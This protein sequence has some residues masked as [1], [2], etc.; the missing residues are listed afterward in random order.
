MSADQPERRCQNQG[1]P[2]QIERGRRLDALY[3]S[4]ECR[5]D[6]RRKERFVRLK[7]TE[8]HA[9]SFQHLQDQL[10]YAPTEAVRYA[11]LGD[12]DAAGQRPRY[13]PLGRRSKHFDNKLYNI[14]SYS[15]RPFEPPRVPRPGV[16]GVLLFDALGRE[17]KRPKALYMGV[18]IL[19]GFARM[20][21]PG[22][23]K[24]HVPPAMERPDWNPKDGK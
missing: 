12:E 2:N 23:T 15:L 14:G 3:C 18:R 5:R 22:Q 1:C 6:A 8:P 4:P 13:P 9:A 11:L 21:L 16:Y 7:A 19:V 20:K 10:A 17:V 24:K